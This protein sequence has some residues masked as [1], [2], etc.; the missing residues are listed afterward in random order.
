MRYARRRWHAPVV[1][2]DRLV[3]SPPV[4]QRWVARS[5]APKL[6]VG[7]QTR[8]VEAA[9]DAVGTWVPSVPALAVVPHDPGD[10]W[11]LAA[12]VLAPAA[13]AWLAHG[14]SGP[15][16]DRAPSRWPS[17]TWPRCPSPADTEAW[18]AAPSAL[19]AYAADPRPA[20]LDRY[21]APPRPPMAPPP[22]STAWWRAPGRNRCAP[23]RAGAVAWPATS[24]AVRPRDG[25]G[26]A[27]W[28]GQPRCHPGPPGMRLTRSNQ[29][30]VPLRGAH[31]RL[32]GPTHPSRQ[33]R[34]PDPYTRPADRASGGP[35]GDGSAAGPRPMTEHGSGFRRAHP[36]ALPVT[37]AWRPGDPPG[38][39][40]FLSPPPDRPFAL[41][42]GG[43][44]RGVTLAYETWGELS[45]A[46]D[47]A[48]LVCHALTG[49]SHA[50]GGLEPGHADARLVGR[51]RRPG[52]RHRHR[53]LVRGVRQRAR[54]LPGHHRPGVAAPRRRPALGVALPGGDHPRH[55][56][57]PGGAWP[58]TWA[59][60]AGR[61]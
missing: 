9:V 29:V 28:L 50:A 48:V 25:A 26:P 12:A 7:T 14:R 8:V 49:D 39:R 2:L 30:S 10:L 18:D 16:L 45:P 27:T 58:T 47:N 43:L 24:G 23:G 4:A 42:G 32:S 41:E 55:G 15:A 40:R 52:P 1:D 34:W 37:G 61:W 5:P 44:L 3:A 53:P 20:R 46:A 22:S 38:R 56:A 11:L 6:V 35:C 17:P 33:R 19:C 13:T 51:H 59:S 31:Q 21:L 54:R 60:T 57:H 36:S